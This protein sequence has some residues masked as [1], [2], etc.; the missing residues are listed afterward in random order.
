MINEIL[1]KGD[2]FMICKKCK[3]KSIVRGIKHVKCFKCDKETT[4]NFV[5]SNI[6]NICNDCSDNYL[7]CQCCG[8]EVKKEISHYHL[9]WLQFAIENFKNQSGISHMIDSDVKM[10]DFIQKYAKDELSKIIE[11]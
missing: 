3:N 7:I 1:I 11:V 5:Y 9:S 6:C 10:G 2:K 8:K 4:V